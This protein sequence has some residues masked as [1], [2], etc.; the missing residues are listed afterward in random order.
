MEVCDQLPGMLDFY[1]VCWSSELRLVSMFTCD[2]KFLSFP[3]DY[4][5]FPVKNSMLPAWSWSLVFFPSASNQHFLVNKE[6]L[7]FSLILMESAPKPMIHKMYDD[8]LCWTLPENSDCKAWGGPTYFWEIAINSSLRKQAGQ[9]WI[10]SAYFWSEN[11]DFKP[12]IASLPQT[13]ENCGECWLHLD[14]FVQ[15]SALISQHQTLACLNWT[16]PPHQSPELHVLWGHF[17]GWWVFRLHS[18][19]LLPEIFT[20]P[21]HFLKFNNRSFNQ[22]NPPWHTMCV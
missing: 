14:V 21:H 19:S 22:K 17:H 3:G 9:S 5:P 11:R 8:R 15:E 4:R 16:F 18:P 12:L 6:K 10:S 13:L 1:G 20:P 2:S 7:D